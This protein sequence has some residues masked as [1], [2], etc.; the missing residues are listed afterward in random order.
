MKRLYLDAAMRGVT[1]NLLSDSQEASPPLRAHTVIHKTYV[2]VYRFRCTTVC[3]RDSKR[4]FPTPWEKRWNFP[5]SQGRR[6][7]SWG[8]GSR[9][10]RTAHL[11]HRAERAGAQHL[12]LF[13]FRLLQDPQESLVGSFS[14]GGER[15]NQV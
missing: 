10:D 14:L 5:N 9:A 8:P 6:E 3:H 15:L 13:E 12:D 7:H 11:V 2:P 1:D 4:F